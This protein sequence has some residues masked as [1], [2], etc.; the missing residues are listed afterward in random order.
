MQKG[1]PVAYASQAMTSA[2]QNCAQIEKEVLVIC[3]ATSKFHQY[4]YGKPN[5]SVQT[6]HK[7]LESIIEETT[8]KH[9]Q[10]YNG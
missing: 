8:A 2:E 9:C 3:F 1:K 10:D 5:V 6:D 7:P 4:V